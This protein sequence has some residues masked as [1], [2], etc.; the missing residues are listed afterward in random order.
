[1]HF[2]LR[3]ERAPQDLSHH[4]GRAAGREVALVVVINGEWVTAAD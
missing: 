2:L 1:M 4:L 3:Q